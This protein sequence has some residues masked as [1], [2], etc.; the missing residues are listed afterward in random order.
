MSNVFDTIGKDI[1]T[2]VE[3]AGK[4]IKDAVEYAVVDP[5]GFTVKAI[6][7]L[8]AANADSPAVKAAF[9]GLFTQANTLEGA[10]STEVA[11]KGTNIPEYVTLFTE[12]K[13]LIAYIKGSL[14]PVVEKTYADLKA[15]VNTPS[16]DAPAPAAT[17]AAAATATVAK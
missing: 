3:D 7:V 10:I 11:A 13:A 12:A 9:E 17:T 4:G 16:P 5:V 15:G 14:I 2:G 6:A 8:K 1:K